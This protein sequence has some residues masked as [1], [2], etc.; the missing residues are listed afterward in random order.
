MK[1][2][3]IFALL[4]ISLTA[5]KAHGELVTLELDFDAYPT[6]ISFQLLL[7]G[8][9]QSFDPVLSATEGTMGADGFYGGFENATLADQSIAFVWDVAPADY[10]FVIRDSYGDGLCCNEGS[11]SYSIAVP[12][13]VIHESTGEFGSG[14]TVAFSLGSPQVT[15]SYALNGT[16]ND[17]V[18][19]LPL[20]GNG[21]FFE[22]GRYHFD[23]NQGLILRNGLTNTDIYSVEVAL[24]VDTVNSSFA[25]LLDFLNLGSDVGIY[26]FGEEF[27]FYN[28]G[29]ESPRNIALGEDF[30]FVVTQN[31]IGE[32][33]GYVDGELQFTIG[34]GN[35]ASSPDNVLHFMIDD[36][37]TTQ[38][39]SATGSIDYIR[40]YD[41]AL[42]D[43]EVAALI[44][45]RP[46]LLGDT[47]ASY[48]SLGVQTLNWWDQSNSPLSST[49]ISPGAEYPESNVPFYDVTANFEQDRLTITLDGT[50][51][52]AVVGPNLTFD[53]LDFESDLIDLQVISNTFPGTPLAIEVTSP[54]SINVALAPIPNLTPDSSFEMVL[55]LITVRANDSDGDGFGAAVDNCLDT[56]NP[57]QY[58]SDGDGFG[59]A[60]DAD[61]NGDCIVNATDLGLL[62]LAFFG[63]PAADNWNADADLNNDEVINVQD[64][65]ALRAQFFAP[66]GP[67]AIASCD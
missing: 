32:T 35:N 28:F 8:E 42:S 56:A 55:E 4:L 3:T 65:G 6:D 24:R 2:T 59:N 18:G 50:S 19:G 15:H 45:P 60:C 38:I 9:V 52:L 23:A 16:L 40:I 30:V 36:Q 47:I 25:K 43:A 7:N 29:F 21:G 12:A 46:D 5:A 67:S 34:G 41:G 48:M 64:L 53:D 1:T 13:G 27:I 14:E 62:R 39:E 17:S 61:F 66:P 11:G 31:S 44:P 26:L 58:D 20:E 51:T 49:V 37:V 63:T 54:T 22:G 10:E 57:D 33:R